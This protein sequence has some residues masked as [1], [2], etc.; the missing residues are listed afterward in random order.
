MSES[1]EPLWLS[2]SLVLALHAR[3]VERFGGSAN[4]RDETLLESALS[5]PK[6]IYQYNETASIH[7]LAA[8]YG[9]GIIR[10]HPFVDGNKRT[11]ALVIRS[12]LYK[13]GYT[14]SPDEAEL[15]RAMTGTAAGRMTEDN[16]AGWIEAC[17][18]R[19]S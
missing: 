19:A 6:H 3:T 5:R 17:T 13:N 15:V 11:G 14:F 4:V 2:K 8:A 10:S 12:F 1:E 18:S 7:D 9:S 16:L